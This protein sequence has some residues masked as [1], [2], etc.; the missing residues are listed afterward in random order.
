MGKFSAV[1]LLVAILLVTMTGGDARGAA[2]VSASTTVVPGPGV[3]S[4]ITATFSL[5]QAAFGGVL[6]GQNVTLTVNFW[7]ADAIFDDPIGSTTVNV[8]MPASG[9]ITGPFTTP[10]VV[11]NPASLGNG[12]LEYRAT[13]KAAPGVGG[14]TFAFSAGPGGLVER[15]TLLATLQPTSRVLS[16]AALA[17]WFASSIAYGSRSEDGRYGIHMR[18]AAGLPS[19]PR[20]VS[21]GLVYDRYQARVRDV[22]GDER[23]FDFPTAG[24]I[25]NDDQADIADDLTLSG[26]PVFEWGDINTL[27]GLLSV[28]VYIV[29]DQ[30]G[31][32]PVPI[33]HAR[34]GVEHVPALSLWGLCLLIAGTSVIAWTWHVRHVGDGKPRSAD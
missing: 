30:G 18:D 25:P 23:V 6:G 19:V 8:V 10:G 4:T 21:T 34:L 22:N 20:L 33:L 28:T 29:D 14:A 13:V 11:F 24:G 27:A 3:N 16:D 2:V 17:P 26:F 7:E 32:P 12:S 1:H 31:A 9:T 15:D 5:R